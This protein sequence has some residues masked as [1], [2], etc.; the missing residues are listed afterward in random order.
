[1]RK[2]RK[3]Q[4]SDETFLTKFLIALRR[5]KL[6]D[7]INLHSVKYSMASYKQC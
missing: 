6:Y 1:M 7:A 2:K 4:Q 5:I 3:L